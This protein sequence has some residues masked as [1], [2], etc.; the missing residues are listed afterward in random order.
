M[1]STYNSFNPSKHIDL[2]NRPHCKYLAYVNYG[3]FSNN[4][5]ERV[6][7]SLISL[8]SKYWEHHSSKLRESKWSRKNFKDV[9]K[10]SGNYSKF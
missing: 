9:L 5:F 2:T 4:D 10:G 1:H 7:Q 3:A 6:F 8:K